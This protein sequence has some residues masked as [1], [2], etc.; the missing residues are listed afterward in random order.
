MM[1]S[2]TEKILDEN[3][4][5]SMDWLEYMGPEM[6]KLYLEFLELHDKVEMKATTRKER[7]AAIKRMFEISQEME[8]IK[9]KKE[10]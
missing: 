7:R 4:K 8:E 5:K 2:E 1:K 9:S 6:K 10:G 3:I